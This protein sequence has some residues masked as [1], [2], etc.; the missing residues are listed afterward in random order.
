[1]MMA[2][3]AIQQEA[4]GTPGAC[5][6]FSL[7]SRSNP[8]GEV[9][10]RLLFILFSCVECRSTRWWLEDSATKGLSWRKQQFGS[11]VSEETSKSHAH[12]DVTH[13][14]GLRAVERCGRVPY[15]CSKDSRDQTTNFPI[16]A[17]SLSRTAQSASSTGPIHIPRQDLDDDEAS[18]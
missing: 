8:S 3:Q 17:R 2:S 16:V 12:D 15:D 14:T 6:V 1:M 9:G 11:S 18:M 5:R 10:S 13:A 7:Q 4:W